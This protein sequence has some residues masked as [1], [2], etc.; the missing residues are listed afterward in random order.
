[1]DRL[2]VGG[3]GS[4]SITKAMYATMARQH[5]IGSKIGA[6]PLDKLRPSHIEA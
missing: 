2:N 3:V 6:Q 5:L 4:Q 1:V